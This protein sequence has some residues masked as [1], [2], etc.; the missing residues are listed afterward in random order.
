MQ[1]T[2]ATTHPFD[3]K[4]ASR[5]DK[6]MRESAKVK[7]AQPSPKSWVVVLEPDEEY[8]NRF[9]KLNNSGS[10][11]GKGREFSFYVGYSPDFL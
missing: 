3:F 5:V 1:I 7:E 4:F 10:G 8:A 2:V 11:G 9:T 6:A